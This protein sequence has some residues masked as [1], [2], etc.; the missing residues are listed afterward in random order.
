MILWFYD[1]YYICSWDLIEFFFHDY[2]SLSYWSAIQ[3]V[4]S[5]VCVLWRRNTNKEIDVLSLSSI[6]LLLLKNFMI[7]KS[8][9]YF[10]TRLVWISKSLA[11]LHLHVFKYMYEKLFKHKLKTKKACLWEI[12]KHKQG[13]MQSGVSFTVLAVTWKLNMLK[14]HLDSGL[15]VDTNDFCC[16]VY[17]FSFFFFP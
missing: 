5:A 6:F 16:L 4:V 12:R 10:F 13:T 17:L 7:F 2:P 8:S 3:L 9:V 11:M 1:R 14:K 15:L